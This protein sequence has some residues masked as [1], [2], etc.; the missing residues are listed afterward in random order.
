MK[1]NWRETP[2]IPNRKRSAVIPSA[3][4]TPILCSATHSTVTEPIQRLRKTSTSGFCLS[5]SLHAQA[6]F[7]RVPITQWS[8]LKYRP[9]TSFEHQA[10][11]RVLWKGPTFFKLCPIV[12]NCLQHIFSKGAKIFRGEPPLVT[13]LLK[14]YLHCSFSNIFA[15]RPITAA[16]YNLS[17]PAYDFRRLNAVNMS[18]LVSR[19]DWKAFQFLLA[20]FEK[21]PPR[22]AFR[23]GA[24]H[25]HLGGASGGASFATRGS[26]Q[27][28]V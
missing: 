4:S 10:G 1:D 11:R 19:H 15:P 9:A 25:F 24:R 20:A 5:S 27:L 18:G 13:R 12:L 21:F 14:H 6:T 17:T 7:V 26:C 8:S 28:S 2:I 23:G 3:L 22:V 16:P